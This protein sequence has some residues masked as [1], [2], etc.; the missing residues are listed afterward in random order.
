[1]FFILKQRTFWPQRICLA[2]QACQMSAQEEAKT[3]GMSC[4]FC[5]RIQLCSK[6][7]F[8][9]A[10]TLPILIPYI[11]KQMY[12]GICDFFKPFFGVEKVTLQ[13]WKMRKDQKLNHLRG[14]YSYMDTNYGRKKV[15]DHVNFFVSSKPGAHIIQ[16]YGVP[17]VFVEHFLAAKLYILEGINHIFGLGFR[18]LCFFGRRETFVE[19]LH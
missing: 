11:L 6:N 14:K 4:F 18:F 3:L 10:I 9:T 16:S 7:G 17:K 5:S 19:T 8:K 15:R 1:M 12:L 13:R 2:R